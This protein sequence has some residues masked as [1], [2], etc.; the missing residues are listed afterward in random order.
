M[1]EKVKKGEADEEP[2]QRRAK[3][4]KRT[5]WIKIIYKCDHLFQNHRELVFLFSFNLIDKC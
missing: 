5:Q 3:V 1:T 4:K 2:S